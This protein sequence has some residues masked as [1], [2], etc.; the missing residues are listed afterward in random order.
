[1]PVNG[2]LTALGISQ[3]RL[4]STTPYSG[5]GSRQILQGVGWAEAGFKVSIWPIFSA[6]AA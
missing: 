6:A 2:N 5:A 3:H 1:M 4:K